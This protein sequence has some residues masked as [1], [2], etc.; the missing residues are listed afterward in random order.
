[1]GFLGNF[2]DSGLFQN[3]IFP[4][5]VMLVV[6]YVLSW[7]M[8]KKAPG[9]VILEFM[10]NR[11]IK[12]DDL[13][14]QVH[15]RILDACEKEC[16]LS[17]NRNVK[18]L[19]I[20]ST[21]RHQFTHDGGRKFIGIVKGFSETQSYLMVKFKKSWWTYRKFYFVAP[22]ELLL[23][24]SSSRNIIFEGT[25]V[26]NIISAVD[27][28]YPSPSKAFKSFD[29]NRMDWWSYHDFYETLR[30]KASVMMFT[31]LGETT[32]LQSASSTAQEKLLKDALISHQFRQEAPPV[33][34]SAQE[35]SWIAE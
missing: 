6:F 20:E 29:E 7:M 27:F 23:S 12:I 10:G 8:F 13:D 35:P 32:G 33:D 3:V 17:D 1:M 24:S 2:F 15:A 18:Y 14:A 25:S 16:K 22:P 19:W 4:L 21:A 9:T 5:I 31:Q 11:P 34:E 30:V 26:K 28:C